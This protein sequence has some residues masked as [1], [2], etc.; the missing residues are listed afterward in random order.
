MDCMHIA[1]IATKSLRKSR[2]RKIQ[3]TLLKKR[4]NID[5]STLN[6]LEKPIA[7]IAPRTLKKLALPPRS[8]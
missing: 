7:N 6:N 2:E 1:K 4:V 5:R 3:K 8:G